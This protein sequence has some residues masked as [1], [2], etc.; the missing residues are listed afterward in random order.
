MS[1]RRWLAIGATAWI[2]LLI[3]PAVNAA[4]AQYSGYFGRNKV[5]YETFEFQVLKTEHFDIFYYEGMEEVVEL[6]GRMAE[7]W[8]ARLSRI[9]N[10]E[11]RSR[12]PIILYANHAHFEQTN[13]TPSQVDEST[14]GFT[15]IL[16][17][18]IVLPLAATL[19]ES[20]HVLGHELVH[21][22]QF[23]MTGQGPSAVGVDVPGAIRLPLW[24]IEGMAEYL[25][26]GPVDPFTT[27]WMRDALEIEDFPEITELNNRKYFPYRFGHAFWSYVAGHYGEDR[28]G[29]IL[30]LAGRTAN[31]LGSIEAVLEISI[32]ELSERW[33]Q[34]IEDYFR[35]II[36][37][38]ERPDVFGRRVIYED[39]ADARMN[40]GPA[41]SPSGDDLAYVSERDL[42]SIEMFLADANTGVVKS[43]VT[44]TA[45]DPHFESL[46]FIN[47]AGS[48]HPDG[49]QFALSAVTRGRPVVA[50]LDIRSGDRLREIRL[51]ELGEIF[52]PV[53]SPDGTKVAFAAQTDGFTDIYTLDLETE[54][55][56]QLTDDSYGD[57]QPAWSPDGRYIAFV[58]ERYGA[59]PETLS[60]PNYRLAIYD[61]ESDTLEPLPSFEGAKNINPQWTPDGSSLYFVSDH[62]GISNIYRLDMESQEVRLVTNVSTG[63][64]G[65]TA[66]SPTLSVASET[67]QLAFSANKGGPFSFEIYVID[68]ED[69]L[70]GEPVP[71]YLTDVDPSVI[72]PRERASLEIVN[73]LE[74]DRLG[75][76]DP[77]TFAGA[78][79]SPRLSLD[80]VSQPT[81][82]FGASDFGVFFAGG[83]AVQFSDLL[84]NRT[85]SALLQIN[86]TYGDITK[87]TALLVGYQNLASRWNWGVVGGQLPFVTRSFFQGVGDIEGEDVL[88]LAEQRFFQVSRQVGASFAYP[89]NRAQRVEIGASLQQLDYSLEVEEFFF[90]PF[91]GQLLFE[92]T[93]DLQAPDD[94][95]QASPTVALVYDTSIFGGT[96]PILGTRYR[97]EV[98][99]SFGTLNFFT[100]LADYRKYVMIARPFSIAGRLL[101][102]GRYGSDSDDPRLSQ[103]FIGYPSLVRGYNDD[104]FSVFECTLP[105]AAQVF[106]CDV[107]DQLLGSKIAVGNL[108]ARLP[109]LG[110]IGLIP[111]PGVPPIEI[112]AFFD[113]GIAW[114]D[115]DGERLSDRSVVNSVGFLAR[116]NLFG[117][118]IMELD[119]V[120][121]LDRPDKD[122]F[123]QFSFTAGF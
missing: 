101:H 99:P 108:E 111:A 47:S 33:H 104:S 3:G 81:I 28:I 48:W 84:G 30:K 109:L 27:M 21:A 77:V 88:V 82:A 89:I 41:I 113:S 78:E 117:F 62:D 63:V 122:W 8:Y 25:T 6:A 68:E 64:S 29:R 115:E 110:E 85:L 32:D 119:Y 53:W 72:P 76:A 61:L 12:Q 1:S 112:G 58:T 54:A 105:E 65:L 46:Q 106:Q 80:Y 93:R 45:V 56:R 40:L 100:G 10:H 90:D 5:Q 15:E 55:L 94:L 17:R 50:V 120:N 14:G 7:R 121:P 36:E 35:P 20:D 37:E 19:Q 51:E 34:D 57:L 67:G 102:F 95:Y 26:I 103:L 96:S 86:T 69:I 91:T 39:Q 9:L 70:V 66:L 87:G 13:A 73:L 16:K 79:Y 114:T 71:E 92:Q 24:F 38:T 52:T 22:F 59:D 44:K 11:F 107:F 43:K 60:F 75:L 83:A 98:S 123:F 42:F 23:D 97:L 118:A 18:R 116:L 2:S 4:S 74:N 49:E 31:P